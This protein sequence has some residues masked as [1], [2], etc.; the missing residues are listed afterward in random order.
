[1]D[2]SVRRVELMI[3]QQSKNQSDKFSSGKS[4]CTFMLMNFYFIIFFLVECSEFAA[5]ILYMAGR[6]NQVIPEIGIASF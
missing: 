5:V 3:G 1:M 2:Y 6:F 4:E